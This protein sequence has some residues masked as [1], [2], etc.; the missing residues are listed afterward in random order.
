MRRILVTQRAVEA[1]EYAEERDALDIRWGRFLHAAGLLPVLVPSGFPVADLVAGTKP[2]GLLLTGGND[3]AA[4][5]DSPASRRR[6]AIET[7]LVEFADRQGIPIL[8]V[9]RGLQLL[10]HLGGFHLTP[11]PAHVGTRHTIRVRAASRWLGGHDGLEV[12]SYHT[13]GLGG[14]GQG[15]SEVA[16]AED[17]VIEAIEHDTCPRVGIMWHPEREPSPRPEDLALFRRLFC[18]R[19]A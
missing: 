11:I 13:V 8:G 18:P 5:R 7:S 1:V 17:G 4:F 10:G 16:A 2:E 15:W 14:A 6:D 9:C 12:N 19:P 3:I